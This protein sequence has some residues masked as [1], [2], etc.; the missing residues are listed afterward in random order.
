MRTYEVWL[1]SW[2]AS[3]STIEARIR[4][5]KNFEER[6]GDPPGLT[7]EDLA[8][9][10]ASY[11]GW[12]RCTY[13]N[14]LRSYF[15][16]LHHSGRLPTDP[17]RD[18]RPPRK[19]KPR[20]RPVT[21]EELARLLRTPDRDARAW[22][23][24]ASLAGLRAHEIAKIRGEDVTAEFIYVDGKGGQ[25]AFLPTHPLLWDLAQDYPRKGWWFPGRGG[26]HL[27]RRTV[28]NKSSRI[29]TDLGIEGS[30]HRLR[31]AYATRL[32]RS[33]T[34]IRVVQTLMRHESMTT[35][36]VYLGVTEDERRAAVNLLTAA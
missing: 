6:W 10:L 28:T 21:E 22:F 16:W 35:T 8:C 5:A 15:G 30:V 9:W 31:H 13:Y 29:F 11:Q 36:A 7:T 3:E 20:P 25:R 1:R 32:L 4:I 23:L 18:L 26:G 33:G 12:T 19:P 14:H 2:G 17:T 34:S 27:H 24:L